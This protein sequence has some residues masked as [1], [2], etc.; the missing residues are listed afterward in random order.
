MRLYVENV[1]TVLGGMLVEWRLMEECEE[2]RR[3]REQGRSTRRGG[4]LPAPKLTGPMRT[5]GGTR[6]W[7]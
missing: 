1:E 3:G 2:T 4:D 6:Q 7:Q 5:P